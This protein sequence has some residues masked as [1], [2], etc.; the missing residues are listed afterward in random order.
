MITSIQIEAPV[1]K[2]FHCI[3]KSLIEDIR[4]HQK[5]QKKI[6]LEKDFHYQKTLV[7][8][9]KKYRAEVVIQEYERNH[10]IESLIRAK[11]LNYS[12]GY[13]LIEHKKYTEVQ[14]SERVYNGES[15]VK[16]IL[17]SMSFFLKRRKMREVLEQ[18][19]EA[20]ENS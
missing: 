4:L 16:G 15:E 2:V 12:V 5:K 1:E 6:L 20:V 18:L 7:L 9:D 8:K 19:K 11:N 14:Y 17:N 10:R 13:E 3:E